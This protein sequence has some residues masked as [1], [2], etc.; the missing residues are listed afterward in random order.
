MSDVPIHDAASG[1]EGAFNA[2]TMLFITAVG[3]LAFIAMYRVVADI[4][5][6]MWRI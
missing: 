6:S 4:S 1:G 5:P 3:A 2:T